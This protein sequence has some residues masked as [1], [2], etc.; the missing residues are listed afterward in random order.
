MPEP[1]PLKQ[2][3]VPFREPPRLKAPRRLHLPNMNVGQILDGHREH[4]QPVYESPDFSGIHGTAGIS[5][6][7]EEIKPL[8]IK[9]ATVS[10]KDRPF[11]PSEEDFFSGL[12]RPNASEFELQ[13]GNSIAYPKSSPQVGS[14]L[15]A[16]ID[17]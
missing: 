13:G 7:R 4:S 6:F 8:E 17:S 10:E 16:K 3:Q 14:Q 15:G 11:I 12:D 5:N 9:D 1:L 2:E